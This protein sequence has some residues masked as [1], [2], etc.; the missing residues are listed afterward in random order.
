MPVCRVQEGPLERVPAAG[1]QGAGASEN[2]RAAPCARVDPV[3]SV[4]GFAIAF[5]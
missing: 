4:A 1:C 3:R 5:A 2:D